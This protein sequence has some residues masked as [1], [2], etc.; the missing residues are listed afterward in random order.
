V[1]RLRRKQIIHRIEGSHRYLLT[2]AGRAIAVLFTKT[3]GRVLS[4]GLALLDPQLPAGI[5]SRSPLALAW[6]N[7]TATLDNFIDQGLAPA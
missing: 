1:W 5:A 7:L 6:K 4:P 2:P 3:Y